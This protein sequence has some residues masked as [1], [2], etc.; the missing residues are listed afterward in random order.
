MEFKTKMQTIQTVSA[1]LD[2][3]DE[4]PI[5]ADVVLPDYCP[6]VA[7]ILTCE[8]VPSVTACGQNGDKL[9]ADGTALLRVLYLDEERK[10]VYTYEMSQAF[11]ASF[12]CDG[13]V[14]EM[15]ADV[16]AEADYV[17]CRA[18]S[19][20]RLDIHGAVRVHAAAVSTG[21]QTALAG[22]E[23]GGVFLKTAPVTSGVPA[24]WAQKPFSVNEALGNADG[25][26]RVVRSCAVPTVTETKVLAGKVIV[27]GDL[28][29]TALLLCDGDSGKTAERRFSLPFSQMV[30][31]AGTD[32]N[33]TVDARV[34]VTAHH[35][36]LEE[37]N[38]ETVLVSTTKL[39]LSA[40]AW[41]EET[42]TVVTDVYA[43]AMPV[44]VETGV[45]EGRRLLAVSCEPL[46]VTETFPL[47]PDTA[48]VLSAWCEAT[49]LSTEN[50]DGTRTLHGRLTV[51]LLTENG[52]GQV[53]YTDR[54]A[55]FSETLP[56]VGS[57]EETAFAVTSC[58]TFSETEGQLTVK[59]SL[60]ACRRQY[61]QT[62]VTAVTGCSGDESA[63]YPAEAAAVKIVYAD[64]GENLWDVAKAAH[65]SVEALKIENELETDVLDKRTM[66]L[67]PL[68]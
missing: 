45:I 58:E 63:A 9:T 42:A 40:Q 15:A 59:V 31:L 68:V 52:E 24:G 64:A 8:L 38:G 23:D 46:A 14:G 36:R 17:H 61:E 33:T 11:A 37:E 35:L 30:D 21:E 13:R 26:E 16:T 66:L 12:S 67:V 48:S 51:H 53:Q 27:K 29:I 62:A 54:T 4:R 43:A 34:R 32:E 55:E 65:T 1:L 5:D 41:K 10:T 6:D 39:L 57:G 3:T 25:A 49:P 28:V 19:P 56:A 60:C 2:A 22:V 18:V 44:S 47:L 20:R 50:G 7:A